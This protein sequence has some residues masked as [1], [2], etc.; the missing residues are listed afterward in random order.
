MA[1]LPLPSRNLKIGP[2]KMLV[3]GKVREGRM[4]LFRKLFVKRILTA[5][6][7]LLSFADQYLADFA[8]FKFS[9]DA[10]PMFTLVNYVL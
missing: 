8:V 5:T 2:R 4:S 9:L 7:W 10:V 1:T 3:G 6:A